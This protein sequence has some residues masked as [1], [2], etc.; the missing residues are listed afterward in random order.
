[1]GCCRCWLAAAAEQEIIAAAVSLGTAALEDMA[2][3]MEPINGGLS[4][5]TTNKGL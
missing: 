5:E 2:T 4:E 3:V 1:M